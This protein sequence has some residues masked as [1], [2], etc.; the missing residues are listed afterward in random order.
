[1]PVIYG[2]RR[3]I[4]PTVRILR[5]HGPVTVHRS[6]IVFNTARETFFF[7]KIIHRR[8]IQRKPFA[9][10]PIDRFEREEIRLIWPHLNQQRRIPVSSERGSLDVPRGENQFERNCSFFYTNI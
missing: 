7:T 8:I 6:G 5:V 4:Y 10:A 1:M 9:R 2:H 3:Q